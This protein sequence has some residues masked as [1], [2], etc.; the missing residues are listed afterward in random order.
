MPD[1]RP[2]RFILLPSLSP[3]NVVSNFQ[4]NQKILLQAPP[5][6]PALIWA[7]LVDGFKVKVAYELANKLEHLH[8]SKVSTYTDPRSISELSD[9]NML[10]MCCMFFDPPL[11]SQG[12]RALALIVENEKL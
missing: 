2:N 4:T 6:R 5:L 11:V 10:A 7:D 3:R 8:R 1:T 12:R 9:K